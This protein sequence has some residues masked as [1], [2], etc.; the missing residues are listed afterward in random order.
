MK[1]SWNL[2]QVISSCLTHTVTKGNG[3]GEAL[4]NPM[5][6]QV[7]IQKPADLPAC[8]A[9]QRLLPYSLFR[10]TQTATWLQEYLAHFK[11]CL[12]PN[13]LGSA[14]W[15]PN[16]PLQLLCSGPDSSHSSTTGHTLPDRGCCASASWILQLGLHL[17][18][19]VP[20]LLEHSFPLSDKGLTIPN[21]GSNLAS[22]FYKAVY[23][24]GCLK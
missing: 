16:V 21:K 1:Q 3:K 22:S 9:P 12:P 4:N 19:E 10:A 14:W 6:R 11:M 24:P 2:S 18:P 15:K 13:K 5:C 23:G 20:Q 8:S 7:K 17:S